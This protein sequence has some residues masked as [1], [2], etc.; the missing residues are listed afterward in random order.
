LAYENV[1]LW[2]AKNDNE[3]IITIDDINDGNKNNTYLCPVCGSNLKPKAVKSKQVTSHFAHVDASKCNS[4]SQIHFWFKHKFIE[5]GDKFTVA[6]DKV[7]EYVCKEILVEKPFETESGTYKPDVTILTECGNTLYFEMAFSNM[8]KIKDYLDMWLELR[9]IVVEVDIKQLMLKDEIPTFKTLFYDGKCFNVKKNDT[10]YNTIGK[11]KEE[12]LRNG[13]NIELRERICK[14]DWFWDDVV[15]FNKDEL[16]VEHM[17]NLI[18]SI[19]VEDKE[20][21]LKLLKKSIC[22]KLYSE[23]REFLRKKEIHFFNKPIIGNDNLIKKA[24]RKL[25][26]A[27]K[28]IDKGYDIYLK[29]EANKYK[30]HTW[31]FGRKVGYWVTSSYNYKVILE[32]DSSDWI[33]KIIDV[34]NLVVE[35]DNVETIYDYFN[36]LIKDHKI[37]VKHKDKEVFNDN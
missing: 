3:Q 19:E 28:K 5:K 4:E 24:V 31:R 29:G 32:H 13:G 10:Y 22:S 27:Y 23:Y 17:I 18:N 25:N 26:N 12:K 6:A 7:K 30:T 35:M 8:K 15:R 34:T 36:N 9:N 37:V 14:L 1:K 16:T 21:I 11:Y 20:V 2:F 33:L